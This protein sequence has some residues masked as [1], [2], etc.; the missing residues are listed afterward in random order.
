MTTSKA[1]AGAAIAL[2][3]L[4]LTALSGC[5]AVD[6]MLHKQET[7]TFADKAAFD[8]GAKTAADWL[9]ADAT[10]ITE[11]RST[12]N[13]GIAVILLTS[14]SELPDTCKDAERRSAPTLN[15]DGAPDIYD[16]K[17]TAA[18]VCGDW[19]VMKSD[20][21]WYGWTPNVEDQAG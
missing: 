16:P 21:G 4:F 9:P 18:H 8:A 13:A 6:D 10:N 17:N 2:S 15:L 12:E 19:T 1:R 7:A 5:A 20:G 3:A 11:R 14:K